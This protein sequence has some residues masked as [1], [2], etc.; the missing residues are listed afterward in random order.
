MSALLLLPEVELPEFSIKIGL[1]L[2]CRPSLLLSQEAELSA[3]NL[4]ET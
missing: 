4:Q 2:S 1:A 3:L